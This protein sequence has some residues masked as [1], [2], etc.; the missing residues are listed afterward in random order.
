MQAFIFIGTQNP[1]SLFLSAIPRSTTEER[2]TIK[3]NLS[4]SMVEQS[5]TSPNISLFQ[6]TFCSCFGGNLWVLVVR[7]R[8]G[9]SR[10]Q[11]VTWL[12]Y[13]TNIIP[14]R[15]T[16]SADPLWLFYRICCCCCCWCWYSLAVASTVVAPPSKPWDAN[17]STQQRFPKIRKQKPREAGHTEI[18]LKS[19]ELLNMKEEGKGSSSVVDGGG[20]WRWD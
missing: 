12:I 4:W 1:Y 6:R 18:Q 3:E 20:G 5:T 19:N 16:S 17:K 9:S 14:E 2:R 15:V 10:S 7:K 11:I 8:T 13:A